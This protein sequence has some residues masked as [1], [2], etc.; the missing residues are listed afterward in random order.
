MFHW[1]NVCNMKV[2]HRSGQTYMPE[3][4]LNIQQALSILKQMACSAMSEC[5]DCNR[6]VKACL[7]QRILQY[8]SDI[9]WLDWL[10]SD[11]FTMRLENKVVTGIP[12][13]ETTE[14]GELLL[15]D[16]YTAVLFA[17]AL[18]DENLLSFKTDVNPLEAACLAYS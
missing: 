11:S 8:D 3:T 2:Y 7:R 18:I 16:G 4:F 14:H 6:V 5:M 13:L 17:F 12:L 10:R 15:R 9:S 1:L